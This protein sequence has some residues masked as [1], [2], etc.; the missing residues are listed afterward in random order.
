MTK[1]F[2]KDGCSCVCLI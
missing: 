1:P 2:N